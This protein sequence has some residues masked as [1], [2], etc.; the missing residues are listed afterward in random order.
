MI[1]V[2]KHGHQV[3]EIEK[4]IIETQ[5]L[6]LKRWLVLLKPEHPEILGSGDCEKPT[7]FRK[8]ALSC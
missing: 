4:L 6:T 7:K 8:V 1:L 3:V 2:S 5:S